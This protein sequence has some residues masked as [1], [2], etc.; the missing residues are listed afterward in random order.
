MQCNIQPVLCLYLPVVTK[1]K[2]ALCQSKVLI[3][4]NFC[5]LNCPE[6]LSS[7]RR[8]GVVFEQIMKHWE[9]TP[10]KAMHLKCWKYMIFSQVLQFVKS[11]KR[12]KS[13]V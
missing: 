13:A 12:I 6:M 9:Y 11:N 4:E 8:S 5:V 10:G 1:R 7:K 2:I 3:A